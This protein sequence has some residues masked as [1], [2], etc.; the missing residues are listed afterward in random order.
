MLAKLLK[1]K[2]MNVSDSI[3]TTSVQDYT[4][5]Y[6]SWSVIWYIFSDTPPPFCNLFHTWMMQFVLEFLNPAMLL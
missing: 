6:P 5:Y 4:P 2:E 1:G 3:E